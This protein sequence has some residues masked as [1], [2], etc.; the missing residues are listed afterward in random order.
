[1][2][3]CMY[4][5][6][7]SYQKVWEKVRRM[8]QYFFAKF[9]SNSIAYIYLLVK[10]LFCLFFLFFNVY[11][12]PVTVNKYVYINKLSASQHYITPERWTG[13]PTCWSYT[14][15]YNIKLQTTKLVLGYRPTEWAKK[16]AV[17]LRVVTSSIMHQFKEIPLLKSLLNFQTDVF[18]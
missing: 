18:C 10:F 11:L 14:H 13:E 8:W 6:V 9:Q 7:C 12:L 15:R 17:V 2:L 5:L 1:M 3:N 4:S 16:W